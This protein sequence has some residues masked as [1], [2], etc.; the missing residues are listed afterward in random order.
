MTKVS[1]RN[2]A[3]LTKVSKSEVARWDKEQQKID[4]DAK[5]RSCDP[6]YL[7]PWLCIQLKLVGKEAFNLQLGETGREELKAYC[8]E[9]SALLNIPGTKPGTKS[10]EKSCA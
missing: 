7:I 2:I 9:I 10:V 3:K 1:L 4:F 5:L 8:N 6:R